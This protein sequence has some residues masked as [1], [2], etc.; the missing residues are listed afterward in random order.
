MADHFESLMQGYYKLLNNTWDKALKEAAAKAIRALSSIPNARRDNDNYLD[1]VMDVVNDRLGNDFAAEM[2]KPTQLFGSEVLQ[3]GIRDAKLQAGV[4]IGLWGVEQE[5]LASVVSKQNVFWLGNHFGADI[6]D[7]FRTVLT[8][9]LQS[10]L[11]QADLAKITEKQFAGIAQKSAVYWEGLARHTALRVREFGR[12][13]GYRQ[14]KAVGYRLIVIVDSRTS[15]I[16]LALNA[17]DKVY[18]LDVALKVMDNLMDLDTKISDL[19]EARE[20]IKACAPWVKEDQ[21]VRNDENF[22]VGVSGTHT[23]F[24]PFHFKCRT[25]TEIVV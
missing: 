18:P 23:P 20:Y 25:T 7:K 21:I 13:E 11:S 10:G 22:P 17:E 8:Q 4:S 6:A 1:A 12:L 16:C 2:R 14:A 19:K 3:L 5:R 9:G 24:P 15:D